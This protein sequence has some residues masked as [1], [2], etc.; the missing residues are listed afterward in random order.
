MTQNVRVLRLLALL[1]ALGLV[2]AACSSDDE[3]G[4]DASSD[5]GSADSSGD[6]SSDDASGGDD[7][8]S[9]A[10]DSTDGAGSGD[11]SVLTV[12]LDTDYAPTTYNPALF[13]NTQYPFHSLL[14]DSLFVTSSEGEI[15]PNIVTDFATNEAGT[16]L[17][18]TLRDDIVFDDGS[19]L[20]AE[21]VK[22]NLDRRLTEDMQAYGIFEEGQE[23]EI[24]D[25]VVDGP[26]EV[27]VNWAFEDGLAN[28]HE[29]LIDTVGAIVGPKGAADI[30]SLEAAPE[31]SGPYTLDLD[32]S[33]RGATY[34]LRK[35]ADHWNADAYAYDTV[36][37]NVI[38]DAQAR[39][40]AVVSGEADVALKIEPNQLSLV[41]A[42][43]GLAKIGGTIASWPILDKTGERIP[44]FGFV[45]ARH[46]LSLAIDRQAIVDALRPGA[47]PTVQFFP[48]QAVGYDP[49][50]EER[51]AYNPERAREL[52]ASVGL[53]DGFEFDKAVLGD[54]TDVELAIQQMWQEELGVTVNY[55]AVANTGELFGTVNTNAAIFNE[56]GLGLRP[57]GFVAG[58]VTSG[59]LNTQGAENEAISA[60][61][62]PALGG[63][64][65]SLVAL[66][67]A[68]IDEGWWIGVYET[69]A[70]AGYNPDSVQEVPFAGIAGYVV[71]A[72][73]EPAG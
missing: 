68:L 41:E 2:A 1:L 14:Y 7:A 43:A 44:A 5:S 30:T 50:L 11:G 24:A 39:A 17:S 36:V 72:D 29:L 34:T 32:A 49:T 10:G 56:W 8:D 47:R 71:M 35:R 23:G 67:N 42:E 60:A 31:G 65:D 45:E 48:E 55:P 25:V 37:F 26:Y 73:I 57:A 53:E 52:L 6:D 4:T 19:P 13:S 20:D 70:Y 12:A 59:F 21:L 22:A 18:F 66:G 27:T 51:Y 3:S 15:V 64:P 33:T 28:G 16:A 9:D 40:N 58:P 46:A 61:L 63:D 54:P 62:G 38:S 69:F